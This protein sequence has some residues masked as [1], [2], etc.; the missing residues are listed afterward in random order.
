V[1]FTSAHILQHIGHLPPELRIPIASARA[2]GRAVPAGLLEEA[3]EYLVA[4]GLLVPLAPATAPASMPS[5][6][7]VPSTCTDI[8][9]ARDAH[10]RAYASAPTLPSRDILIDP[11]FTIGPYD[12]VI[13]VLATASAG[14]PNKQAWPMLLAAGKAKGLTPV[15]I[16]QLRPAIWRRR[17]ALLTE[18][19]VRL[20]DAASA[21]AKSVVSPSH[22]PSLHNATSRALVRAGHRPP[23]GATD[24]M[25]T[26][27]PRNPL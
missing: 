21:V 15:E 23:S 13:E 26:E 27:T 12:H 20:R 1:P 11:K 10:V 14:I 16:T 7:R 5:D 8:D 17:K 24:I 18:Q 9:R 6:E 3:A 25:L 4:R 19:K 22:L 2:T